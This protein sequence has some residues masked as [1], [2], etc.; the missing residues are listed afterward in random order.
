MGQVQ[1]RIT[2]TLTERFAPSHLEVIDESALHAGHMGA[3]PEGETHFRIRI[4]AEAFR[5]KS[6]LQRHRMVNE[7]VAA[8]LAGPVHALAISADVPA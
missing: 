7:A 2:E 3:R 5:D 1:D 4:T 8:E 6:R